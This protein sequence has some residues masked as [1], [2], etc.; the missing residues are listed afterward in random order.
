MAVLPLLA[1]S[2]L[3]L[4]RGWA[5]RPVLSLLATA[6]LMLVALLLERV[7]VRGTV[8]PEVPVARVAVT[9]RVALPGWAVALWAVR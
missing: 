2:A 3:R 4:R 8:G 1:L 6:R 7:S 9:H 5:R